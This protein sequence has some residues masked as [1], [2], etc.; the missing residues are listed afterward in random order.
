MN[1]A[2]DIPNSESLELSG[3]RTGV[4]ILHGFTGS[5][6][7]IA[8]WAH[9]LHN[10]GFTVSA[11]RIAGHGT[12]WSDLNSTTWQDWYR[13]VEDSFVKLKS[14]CDQVFVAGFSA[15]GALA[16]HLSQLRGSEISGTILVNPSIYDERK[17][18]WL[19]PLLSRIIPS[20]KA[21]TSDV[22]KPN[23]PKH[24]Y[25]RLPLRALASLQKLWRRVEEDLYLVDL[26]L[27]V[28]YSLNDHVV[29]PL[30]SETII[31]NVFSMDIR[32]VIFE[33]SFHN[34]AL[35]YD[36]EFLFEESARFIDDVLTGEISRELEVSDEQDLIN[37]EFES[38]IATLDMEPVVSAAPWWR[39]FF[40]RD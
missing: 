11:P 32:E 25:E 29:S 36:A 2:G 13:S 28:S 3:D 30:C 6:A 21:G 19:V 38:I 10:E 7:S 37:A 1:E 8:P 24:G 31:D 15:G 23:P 33:K 20:V 16:L 14:Q 12:T 17:I 22:A 27:M 26:P 40:K 34:V 9:F 39:K 18:F 4:L 5:P 35:D